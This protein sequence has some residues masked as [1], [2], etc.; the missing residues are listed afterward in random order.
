MKKVILL[1]ANLIILGLLGYGVGGCGGSCGEFSQD[2]TVS[3]VACSSNCPFSVPSNFTLVQN[4]CSLSPKNFL[5]EGDLGGNVESSGYVT[6]DTITNLDDGEKFE[7]EGPLLHMYNTGGGVED[8]TMYGR[9]TCTGDKD[10][11]CSF[12]MDGSFFSGGC[13]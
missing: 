5:T 1:V 7:C 4:G 13:S 10:S 3:I 9:Q 8:V 2:T 6:W 12:Y 11:S